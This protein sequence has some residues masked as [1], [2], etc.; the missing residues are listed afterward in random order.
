MARNLA[1]RPP[2][3]LLGR[4]HVTTA[5]ARSCGLVLSDRSSS[6]AN[7]CMH[8]PRR[9]LAL[10]LSAFFFSL[11]FSPPADL[12]FLGFF[13]FSTSSSSSGSG[14]HSTGWRFHHGQSGRQICGAPR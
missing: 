5:R 6:H 2:L 9:Q 8:V 12:S 13:F 7:V 3:L 1:Q 11:S 14:S 4:R 10:A